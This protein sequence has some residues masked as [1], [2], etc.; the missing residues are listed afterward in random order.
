MESLE[1]LKAEESKVAGEIEDPLGDDAE[2]QSRGDE[3]A[4]QHGGEQSTGG[5]EGSSAQEVGE[6]KQ[7]VDAEDGGGWSGDTVDAA[8]RTESH[9][10][11]ASA[12]S[13]VSKLAL[14]A[15]AMTA[16]RMLS[17][18]EAGAAERLEPNDREL[19]SAYSIGERY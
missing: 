12:A 16:E 14:G 7:H 6:V 18:A 19:L 10:N 13:A 17:E 8:A 15:A 9:R 4:Q 1:E 2:E 3:S 5:G 11:V